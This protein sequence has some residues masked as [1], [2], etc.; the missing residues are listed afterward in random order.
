MKNLKTIFAA[1][2]VLATTLT[3]AQEAA[4]Q[5]AERTPESVAKNKTAK[6][7]AELK[8]D[9]KQQKATYDINLRYA[10]MMQEVKAKKVEDKEAAKK[11]MMELNERQAKELKANM[12]D[13][14]QATFD[15]MVA[16]RKQKME[17]RKATNTAGKATRGDAQPK[18]QK[19]A[20]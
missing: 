19:K 3:M 16:E 9:E 11:K 4:P 10:K 6:M 5:K 14:Q 13:E 15:K 12:D 18:E 8:L 7:A 1:G 17:Q 20:E 2:L